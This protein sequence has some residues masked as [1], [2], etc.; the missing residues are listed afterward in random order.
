MRAMPELATGW[1]AVGALWVRRRTALAAPGVEAPRRTSVL[2]PPSW[3]R[4][5]EPVA[6]L[7]AG[8]V[9]AVWKVTGPSDETA[10]GASDAS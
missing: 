9:Q 1:K 7:V 6:G 5:G 3:M 2:A 10:S 4:H 8:R